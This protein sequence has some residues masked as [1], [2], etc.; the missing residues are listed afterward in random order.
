[1]PSGTAGGRPAGG[2]RRLELRGDELRRTL[3]PSSLPFATTAELKPLVGTIGQPRALD[4]IEFGLG[5]TTHGFNIFLAG[6]PGSGRRTTALDYLRSA[7]A[8]LPVPDDWVYVHDFAVP[9][10]PRAIRLPPGGGA[11]FAADIEEL[12]ATARREIPRAFE[13]DDYDRRRRETLVEAN[14]RR[15][16]LEA[17]LV[18][19]AAERDFALQVGPT[20]IASIPLV[21][22]KPITREE[23]AQ[24]DDARREKIAQAGA[25]IEERT[26]SY[27]RRLHQSA[28][29]AAQR[30]QELEREVALYATGPL[31]HELEERY[32]DLPDVLAHLDGVKREMLLHLNDFRGESEPSPAAA[33][34]LGGQRPSFERFGVNVLVD[35]SGDGGAP[36]VTEGN[37]NYHNLLGRIQ[38]RATLGAMVTDF[39]E[40]KPGAIHRASGGFLVLDVLDVLRHPFAWEGLKRTLR[41]SEAR[42]ENLAEEFAGVPSA[43]LRPEPI[44]VS[45]KVV[46]IG[47]PAVYRQLRELDDDFGELF[48]VKAEFS[49]EL[50]WNRRHQRNYAAFVSR[51]VR[52]NDLLHFDRGAVARLIEHG[53]RLRE[54]KQRLSARMMDISDVVA[55]ASYWAQRHGR[56]LVGADDVEHAIAKRDYRSNLLEERVH[57]LIDN[58]TLVIETRGR[59]VGQLNGLAVLDIGDYAFGRPTRVSARVSIGRGS[60]ASIEREIE[61]SGPIHSKGFLILSGYLAA[62]YAQEAPLALSASLTFEQSYDEIDGD[63]AS[64]AELVAL[65]SALAEAPLEQGIAMTGSVDQHG[66]IQAIGGVNHKIE[67]F[68]ATCKARGLTGNQGVII[69]TS[70]VRNLMLGREIVDAVAQGRFHVWAIRT[71]DEALALLS[72][73]QPG[74][75]RRDGSYTP[76]S[77]HARVQ[78]RLAT[79]LEHLRAELGKEEE[80]EKESTTATA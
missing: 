77:V 37:P 47:T 14:N 15:E 4:A 63:S 23:Y 18:Q 57:E 74:R 19:F 12:V 65:L 46:L 59:R 56:T 68:F 50:D 78:A 58:G 13:S 44:P 32:A 76:G 75:R 60:I 36:V 80:E 3:D 49:P 6:A 20:G 62:T 26:A 41:S 79:Y 55:E 54:S 9:D 29:E 53:G 42:I 16:A 5:M 70:N 38:Y 73:E 30:V 31:F 10:R 71:I 8:T 45:M 69:P 1:M 2:G 48:K 43:T 64:A 11:R 34:M 28:K 7:A 66:H 24:L 40:I 52:E 51:L 25:E 67:G 17:E 39:H 27:A 22:G 21:D 72:G 35:N 61:L 33:A